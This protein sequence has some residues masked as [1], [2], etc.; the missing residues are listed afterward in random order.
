MHHIAIVGGITEHFATFM[1]AVSRSVPSNWYDVQ[2]YV[3]ER[4]EGVCTPDE[5]ITAITETNGRGALV[6]EI[7]D[8]ALSEPAIVTGISNDDEVRVLVDAGYTLVMLGNI[9]DFNRDDF[10]FIVV[11]PC[12]STLADLAD[13]I[14]GKRPMKIDKRDLM[15]HY[16]V[17]APPCSEP[18]R[19]FQRK[20][21]PYRA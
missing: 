8:S 6:C 16:R 9:A 18:I 14:V 4:C 11:D 15:A 17:A 19:M 5:F 7:I 13:H 2:R 10:D 21:A 1:R 20:R 12:E 3:R